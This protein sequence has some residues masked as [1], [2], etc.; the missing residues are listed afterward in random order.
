MTKSDT[1]KAYLAIL[2]A[3]TIWGTQTVVGR[4]LMTVDG[5]Y[6]P[7]QMTFIR[8]LMGVAVLVPFFAYGV[9]HQRHLLLAQWGMVLKTTFFGMFC[10]S[11]LSL[12]GLANT[13]ALN[14]SIMAA[15][16]PAITVIVARLFFGQK[17][18]WDM[19]PWIVISF[20]GA[21][22]IVSKGDWH[23]LIQLQLNIGDLFMLLASSV[24]AVYTLYVREKSPELDTFVLLLVNMGLGVL[25]SLMILPW[26]GQLNLVRDIWTVDYTALMVFSAVIAGAFSIGLYS[27][28]VPIVGGVEASIWLNLI[29]AIGGIMAILVLGEDFYAY[30]AVGSLIIAF[31]VYKIVQKSLADSKQTTP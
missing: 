26:I 15:V 17:T 16:A 24:W 21:V 23:A 22:I 7:L 18:Q 3:V 30:H 29:P 13:T 10:Y 6:S 1:I 20:L 27:R 2:L 28:A 19:I 14:A 9:W 5:A 25:I 11:T 8:Q 12:H 4:V 31:S